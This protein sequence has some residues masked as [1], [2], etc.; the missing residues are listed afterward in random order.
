MN[1]WVR[2]K[3]LNTSKSCSIIFALLAFQNYYYY[4]YLLLF[5]RA[6]PMAYGNFQA[7]S[8]IGA[9][10]AGLRHSHSHANS[11]PVPSQVWDL[12]YGSQQ[13]WILNP[14]SKAR[15]RTRILMDTSLDHYCWATG[16]LHQIVLLTFHCFCYDEWKIKLALT[17]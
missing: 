13:C 12:H 17:I 15:D 6:A 7:R 11:T 1:R 8:Q 10:A 2:D 3:R 4:Y 9:V 14:L 5:C 16:E